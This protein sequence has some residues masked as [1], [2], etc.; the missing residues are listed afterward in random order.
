[1]DEKTRHEV[2]TSSEV[3]FEAPKSFQATRKASEVLKRHK[4]GY[5]LLNES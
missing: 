5:K 3:Q 2:R 1:M 4:K